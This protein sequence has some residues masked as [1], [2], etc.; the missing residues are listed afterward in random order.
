MN[1]TRAGGRLVALAVAGTLLA[2]CFD[3]SVPNTNNPDRDRALRNPG[4]V[5]TLALGA[6]ST[7][8]SRWHNGTTT[9]NTLPLVA[10]EHTGTYANDAALELSSEP[11]IPFNNSPISDAHANARAHWEGFYT[12]VS[13]ANEA[14]FAMNN[15]LRIIIGDEDRTL[16]TRTFAKLNQGLGLGYISMMYDQGFIADENTSLDDL[17]NLQLRPWQELQAKA[18]DIMQEV[19]QLTQGANWTFESESVYPGTTITPTLMRQMANTYSALFLV[20]GARTPAERA[21]L[22]WNRVVNLLDQGITRDLTVQFRAT[23]PIFQS[24]YLWRHSMSSPTATFATRGDTKLIGPAD[25]SGR[26][27]DWLSRDW[28]DDQKT[29]FQIVTPDRRI[30]GAAGPTSPGKYYRY[31]PNQIMR[32]ERGLYHFSYYQFY[33]YGPNGGYRTRE[34]AIIPMDILNLIRAEAYYFLNR[35]EEAAAL[36]NITRVANGELPPVTADGVPQ[37]PTCVPRMDGVNCAG[38]LDAIRWERAI[39]GVGVDGYRAYLDNRGSGRL[40]PGTFIH[41]PIPARELETIGV[42][43]YT[44]GGVGQ[45]GGAG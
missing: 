5:E 21:A 28:S 8:W 29:W 9:Y 13:S 38:L 36:V 16:V 11:R 27:A 23:S 10:D 39:E 40:S 33:R 26:Y 41:Y 17:D 37:S 45:P 12:V 31:L 2:G 25:V 42:P 32:P 14:L 19:V 18:L 43:V 1:K 3:L 24:L 20:Y 7:L 22:D 44:W 34:H 4:D 35:R 30:T 15:G 6:W